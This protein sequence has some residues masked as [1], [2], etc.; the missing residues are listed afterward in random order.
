M[1]ALDACGHVIDCS[2]QRPSS[3]RPPT[4]G[5]VCRHSAYVFTEHVDYQ[6]SRRLRC[7]RAVL[8]CTGSVPAAGSTPSAADTVLRDLRF[9]SIANQLRDSSTAGTSPSV[10]VTGTRSAV[11]TPPPDACTG[12]GTGT[13]STV[14]TPPP[15]AIIGPSHGGPPSIVR[16]HFRC[17]VVGTPMSIPRTVHDGMPSIVDRNLS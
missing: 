4:A 17:Y 15:V 16:Y 6:P 10:A 13:R 8:R 7:G 5:H 3:G 2:Y 14:G 1:P 9:W 11:G 12:T